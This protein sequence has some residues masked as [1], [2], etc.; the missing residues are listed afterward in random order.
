MMASRRTLLGGM[1]A[2]GATSTP[3]PS[4]EPVAALPWSG[5]PVFED[6]FSLLDVSARGPDTRWTAHTPWNGDFG[7]AA[8][9][10]PV[11][12]FPFTTSD[13]CLS[14]TAR[15]GEDGH[16][17]S[18][19]LS[20]VD[21]KGRGF[22]QR[23]GYFEARMKVPAGPGVWPAF[24]LATV[25]GNT[26]G[27]EID[28][29]EYYGHEPAKFSSALH[30]WPVKKSS[31]SKHKLLWTATPEKLADDFHLFGVNVTPNTIDFYFDRRK[32]HSLPTPMEL[33]RPLGLLVNL[34]LGSG[35]PIDNTP[36]PSV[37]LVDYVKVFAPV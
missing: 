24:W 3:V 27:V 2:V 13:D 12:G 37:L 11:A 34:A 22:S 4:E 36:N 29:M 6:Q 18:G 19:L 17:R 32:T 7:S 23:F 30:L 21:A 26:T 33:N 16:W 31:A 9:S 20:S 15:K 35:W 28:I 8:F 10:D 1:V 14:I 25:V 5:V